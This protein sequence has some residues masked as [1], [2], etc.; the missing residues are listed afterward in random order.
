VITA[1]S[2]ATLAISAAAGVWLAR[3]RDWRVDVVLLLPCFAIT[4]AHAIVFAHSRYHIPVVPVLALYAAAFWTSDPVKVGERRLALAGAAAS[5]L[6]LV[7]IWGRQILVVDA[8]RI[9]GFFA[10]V[11]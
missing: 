5:V 10:H 11:R 4:A 6:L 3:T 2:Y 8:G 1:I 9:Q 7:T